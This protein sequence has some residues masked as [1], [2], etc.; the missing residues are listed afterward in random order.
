MSGIVGSLVTVRVVM[1]FAQIAITMTGQLKQAH[2]SISTTSY[3]CVYTL[4]A[5]KWTELT[6]IVESA[7]SEPVTADP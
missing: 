7:Y 1:P 2:L 4:C 5:K 6:P 3:C